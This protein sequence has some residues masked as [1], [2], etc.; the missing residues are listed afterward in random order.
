MYAPINIFAFKATRAQKP[1]QFKLAVQTRMNR[2]MSEFVT[3]YYP[4]RPSLY[5]VEFV[6]DHH[7][8]R[9]HILIRFNNFFSI[10]VQET[11]GTPEAAFEQATSK[12]EEMVQF[13]RATLPSEIREA[14]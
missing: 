3:A 4:N 1:F 11:A 7:L 14:V 5:K 13:R 8:I 10:R 12:L 9:C 2:V 6:D